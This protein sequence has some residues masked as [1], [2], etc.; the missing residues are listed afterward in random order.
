MNGTSP[1]SLVMSASTA[2][3]ASLS[4]TR[5]RAERANQSAD[6]VAP[7]VDEHAVRRLSRSERTAD[8]QATHREEVRRRHEDGGRGLDAQGHVA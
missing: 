5:V 7:R 3:G 4:A 2:N 6:G 1:L 8:G